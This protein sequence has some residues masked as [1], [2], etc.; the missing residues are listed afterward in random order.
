[1]IR[2]GSFEQPVRQTDWSDGPFRGH[3]DYLMT[4]SEPVWPAPQAFLVQQQAGWVLAPHFHRTDQF[5]VVVNG[6]GMLGHHALEPLTVHY[7][8]ADTGYGPITAGPDGLWYFTLRAVT[9]SEGFF[10]PEE[11]GRMRPH[12]PRRQRTS[13]LVGVSG[14][15]AL[16]ARREPAVE[17][18]LEQQPDGAAVWL[19][20]LPPGG[21]VVDIPTSTVHGGR[22]HLVVGGLLH[23][24][25]QRLP[26]H[27]AVFSAAED[28]LQ[29]HAGRAGL[30]LLVLQYA[31][32]QGT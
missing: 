20:R 14:R 2:T 32:P 19:L 31:H 9:N 23:I 26:L 8:S 28:R 15:V 5:Q 27:A 24:G 12:L 18:V 11:R 21:D 3:I 4:S 29:G 30:E 6:S 10:L 13:S 22:F 16:L 7:A 1:M 17:Q 25:E